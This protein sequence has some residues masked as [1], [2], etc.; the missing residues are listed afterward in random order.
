VSGV[1]VRTLEFMGLWRELS[2]PPPVLRRRQEARLRATVRAAHADVPFW[3]AR[4]DAAGVRPEEVRTLDELRRLPVLGKEELRAAGEEAITSRAVPRE[5]LRRSHT[6]GSTGQPLAIR[7]TAAEWRRHRLF[8]LRALLRAG[9]RPRDRLVILGPVQPIERGLLQRLG[10]FRADRLSVLLPVEEQAR[11]LQE[12]DPTILWTYTSV[13]R[14][15]LAHL[16]GRLE[17]VCRPRLLIN[18]AEVIDPGLAL[19]APGHRL[20]YRNFYGAVEVGRIAWSCPGGEGLHVNVDQVVLELLPPEAGPLADDP[21]LGEVVVTTLG[22]STVPLIRYRLGDLCRRL[23]GPCPCGCT[24]P[25]I[26]API[27]RAVDLIRLP[28]GALRSPFGLHASLRQ[29]TAFAAFRVVQRALDHISIE[30]VARR[31]LEAAEL[32]RL[33]ERLAAYLREPVRIEF[34]AVPE[35]ARR[36]GKLREFES[37]MASGDGGSRTALTPE[38][39]HLA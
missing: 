28:S 26:T 31:P 37:L 22:R 27:G 23:D 19:V 33:E 39:R 21:A 11:R 36:N 25:R 35:I 32:A 10:L 9:L 18:S 38:A 16:D 5:G 4:L 20:P 15:L 2:R 24:F 29:V 30:Y 14:A 6:S 7:M 3:R 8:E 13:F 1:L 34:V 12:L 17:R